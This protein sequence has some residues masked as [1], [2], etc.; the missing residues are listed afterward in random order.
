MSRTDKRIVGRRILRPRLLVLLGALTVAA[1]A[2]WTGREQGPGAETSLR[3]PDRP[4][5]VGQPAI[6]RTLL[7]RAEAKARRPVTRVAGMEELGMLYQANGFAVEAEACWRE[8]HQL[9]PSDARW[10]YRLAG[11]RLA[12]GDTD[13]GGFLLRRTLD[14]APAYSPAV[15][16]M[17][18][19]KFKTGDL[20]GAARNY[21]RRLALSPRDPYA[22]LGL[23]RLALQERRADEARK[24]VE[25]LLADAPNFATAHNLY[26]QMLEAAGEVEA[27][28]WHRWL[29]VETLRYVP[30]EDPWL[31][32]LQSWCYN[33]NRLCVRGSVEA[34]RK[35]EHG[36]RTLY[37]RAVEIDPAAFAAYRLL[38]ALDFEQARPAEARAVL[39]RARAVVNEADLTPLFLDLCRAYRELEQPELALRLAQEVLAQRENSPELLEALGLALAELARHGEAVEAY[40]TALVQKPNDASINYNLA[41]SLLALGQLD[42]AL[43]ALDLALVMQPTFPPAMLLRGRLEMAAGHWEAAENYL[44]PIFE[45]HR[46]DAQARR[47]LA[48][49]HRHM[50]AEAEKT[51]APAE[52][53]R[54]Y[55]EGASL[56]PD[57]AEVQASLGIFLVVR[58][59]YAEAVEPLETYHRLQPQNAAGCL[60]LGQAYLGVGRAEAARELLARGAELGER[61]GNSRTVDACRE[62]LRRMAT[63]ER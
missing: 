24:L 54:H 48:Q 53:E 60:F 27:A 39:E 22:R 38:A 5:L 46:Q 4:N 21:A 41:V 47:L 23:V 45:S 29:G 2:A 36:A 7:G 13:E 61:T 58:S 6:F 34:L 15:L 25:E 19:L 55:R 3:L 18:E 59:R 30:P 52:A 11:L 40:R 62:I 51:N 32:E 43:E 28:K 31:D 12:A 57:F 20:E 17:A 1:I 35:N 33:Y 56:A 42:D 26:A 49:W 37:E 44:R 8:L 9:E 63:R 50:G 16:Q 14:L 10:C